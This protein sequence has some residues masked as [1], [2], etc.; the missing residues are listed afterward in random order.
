MLKF[1]PF[2]VKLEVLEKYGIENYFPRSAMESILGGDLSRYYPIP[3]HVGL[4]AQMSY[5]DGSLW[6]RISQ[7]VHLFDQQSFSCVTKLS[8]K[9]YSTVSRP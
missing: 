2:P 3:D 1:R 6:Y 4:S 5:R 7:L 9:Y 8:H